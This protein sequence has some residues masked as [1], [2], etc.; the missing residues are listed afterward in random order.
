MVGCQL[1]VLVFLVVVRTE[2]VEV[3]FLF[4]VFGQSL[5]SKV[6]TPGFPEKIGTFRLYMLIQI[7][8]DIC[9]LQERKS[10]CD[11]DEENHPH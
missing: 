1:L 3:F 5:S 9:L 6:V 2:F 4:L 7:I 8:L 11:H 10:S